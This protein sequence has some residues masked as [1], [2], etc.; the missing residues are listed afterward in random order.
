MEIAKK[1][2]DQASVLEIHGDIDG[3]TAPMVQEKILDEM[4]PGLPLLIDMSAVGFMSSAG[5]RVLLTTYRRAVQAKNKVLLVGLSDEIEET[6][7][8]TG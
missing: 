6:M 4:E 8:A 3:H 2:Y 7:S 5:L 1:N